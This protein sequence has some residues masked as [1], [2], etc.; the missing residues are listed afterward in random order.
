MTDHLVSLP[1]GGLSPDV[2]A[3]IATLALAGSFALPGGVAPAAIE[4]DLL[5]R[6]ASK[7]QIGAADV[8]AWLESGGAQYAD[9]ADLV[10]QFAANPTALHTALQQHNDAGGVVLIQVANPTQLADALSGAALHP[11]LTGPAW[12]LRSGYSDEPPY[13]YY[14]D[15]AASAAQPIRMLWPAVATATIQAAIALEPP[16]PPIDRDALLST[17]QSAEAAL[18]DADQHYAAGAQAL[19][20]AKAAHQAIMAS[21]GKG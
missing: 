13:G 9:M 12:L 3:A 14:Y 4:H 5:A 17:L 6:F 1:Q 16:V 10:A 8:L 19:A 7:S 2:R 20:A 15:L 11:G 21:L 18:A